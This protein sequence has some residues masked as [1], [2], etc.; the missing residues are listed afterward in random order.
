MMIR[1]KDLKDQIGTTYP[2]PF[3]HCAKCMQAFSANAG[4]YFAADPE[5]ILKCCGRPMRLVTART[6]MTEVAK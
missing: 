4:D 2:R 6:V 5:T 3:L 1:V